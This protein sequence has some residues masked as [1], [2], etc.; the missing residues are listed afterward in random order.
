M[1][2]IDAFQFYS[3]VAKGIF[4]T[5]RLFDPYLSQFMS[6]KPPFPFIAQGWAFIGLGTANDALFKV[7]TPVMFLCLL[8]IFYSALKRYYTRWVCLLFTFLLSSLPLMLYHVGTAY[9][10][11]PIT[12]Y[13]SV[14]TIYLYLFIKG[15][16]GD[17]PGRA[18]TDLFAAALL[19]GITVWVKRAGLVLV[20]ADLL[21]LAVYLAIANKT[22]SRKDWGRICLA[23]LIF[24][25]IILPWISQGQLGTFTRILGSLSGSKVETALPAAAAAAA[26]PTGEK[27]GTMIAIFT[28]KLFL[29]GDWQLTWTLFVCSLIFFYQRAFRRPLNYL[30]AM[31]TLSVMTI[32]IQFGSGEMFRWLLDGTLF[33]RLIMNEVPIVILFCA[34][35]VIPG[36]TASFSAN[37]SRVSIKNKRGS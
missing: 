24:A 35:A 12:F 33:D 11:F 23:I 34:E 37:E 26:M 29:Y 31:I 19:L 8:V 4:Y 13:F 15:R 6:D 22:I 10:D 32:F 7:I 28:K 17:G 1:V 16:A 3:I 36:L 18:N 9:A 20:G 14:G 27:A 25:L 5:G 2:D 30:L 21:A